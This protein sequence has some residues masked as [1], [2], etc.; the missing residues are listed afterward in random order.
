MDLLAALVVL[1][2]V[3][4]FAGVIFQYIWP[5]LLLAL[6]IYLAI[7]FGAL[8]FALPWWGYPIALLLIYFFIRGVL[9]ALEGWPH[10]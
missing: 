8:L 3:V 5:F 10:Y 6:V 1:V 4:S 7:N 2:I 9:G